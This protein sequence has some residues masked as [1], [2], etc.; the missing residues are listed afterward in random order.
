MYIFENPIDVI[1][2]V[3]A[4]HVINPNTGKEVDAQFIL[5]YLKINPPRPDIA[6]NRVAHFKQWL[7]GDF[8]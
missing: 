1:R 2:A 5:D 8:S 4:E 3:E 7:N 6:N